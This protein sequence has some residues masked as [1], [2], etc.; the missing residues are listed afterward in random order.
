MHASKVDFTSS[1][2]QKLSLP[3]SNPVSP[4]AAPGR[5]QPSGLQP[6]S[7][8]WYRAL[9]TQ[10]ELFRTSLFPIAPLLCG[11]IEETGQTVMV[12]SRTSPDNCPGQPL[13]AHKPTLLF[14]YHS[15]SQI[16][17]FL[18]HLHCSLS[19]PFAHLLDIPGSMT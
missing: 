17:S 16:C 5:Y 12:R 15:T 4:V 13:P 3:S 9:H 14:S 19:P 8:C 7:S 10:P 6:P 2:A 1:L 11:D 18:Y